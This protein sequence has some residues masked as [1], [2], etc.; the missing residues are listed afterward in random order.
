MWLFEITEFEITRVDCK[1]GMFKSVLSNTKRKYKIYFGE[2]NS[3]Y[4]VKKR[5]VSFN[6]IA[7][8]KAKIVGNFG[9]F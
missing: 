6:P 1:Y 8:R 9:H 5:N 3:L 7:L 2:A 4:N